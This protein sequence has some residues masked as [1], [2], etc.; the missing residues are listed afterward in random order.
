MTRLGPFEAKPEL[1][2][3]VSGGADSMALALLADRWAHARGGSATAL[4][5]DHGLRREAAAEARQVARWLEAAGIRHA[6]LR[7][8]P[9]SAKRSATGTRLANLQAA[10]RDARYDLLCGW[11]RDHA[12]LHLLLAHHREDQAETL[13]LRL[14]RGS[15]IE[16][17]AAM[18]P[19]SERPSVRL[20]RPLL[21]LSKAAL[22]AYLEARG[23]AW[24]EDPSNQDRA[25]ARVRMRKLL[26]RLAQ[27]GLSTAR[28]SDTA[29]R[30]AQARAALD[31]AVNRLLA[32][33]VAIFPEGYLR[34]D[35]RLLAAAERELGLRAL[36]RAIT[37]IGGESYG[38]RLERLE[39]LYGVVCGGQPTLGRGRTL[40]GCRI[41]PAR[42]V[43]GDP[44]GHVLVVREPAAVAPAIHWTGEA[45]LWDGRFL[46]G[47]HAWAS[48]GRSDVT[49]G[50]LMEAGLH[51][52][53]NAQ[54]PGRW[55]SQRLPRDVLLTLPAFRRAGELLVVP[56][57][58]YRQG[59]PNISKS[60]HLAEWRAR[61]APKSAL[62]RPGFTLV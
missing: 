14:A 27:E 47:P 2:V 35:S 43:D 26:P 39:R 52:V 15:G 17:L 25:N 57:L 11:C 61:F 50:A 53:S 49:V 38:P 32:Q 31:G 3:A 55:N 41:L 13:L 33:A 22:T 7:W 24:I 48:G 12:V 44:A 16:G 21:H 37:C 1:A 10:A 9:G 6:T 5:V 62:T 8:R 28:L 42:R 29:A 4:T 40:G 58:G 23:Q 36:A 19:M 56:H 46:V 34:L 20:L 18:A 45:M 54:P 59:P 51:E 30:L 60:Q